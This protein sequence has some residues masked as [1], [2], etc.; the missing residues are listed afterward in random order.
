MFL[1]N[2]LDMEEEIK[3]VVFKNLSEVKPK[4]DN[5]DGLCY[6]FANNIKA[7]LEMMEIPVNMVK[8]QL[9][10]SIS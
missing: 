7:D 6:Y 5:L 2:I 4:V 3:F 8:V 10:M 1:G 9:K